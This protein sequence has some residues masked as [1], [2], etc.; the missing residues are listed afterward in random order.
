MEAEKKRLIVGIAAANLVLA[1]L[2]IALT[3]RFNS[4]SPVL[5]D[6]GERL[7]MG[8]TAHI[9]VV[10]ADRQTAQRCIDTGFAEIERIE[11]LMSFHRDDSEISKI[12]RGAFGVPVKVSRQT[13]QLIKRSVEL[14][15]FTGGAFDVTVGPLVNLWQQ[16]GESNSLPTDEELASVRSK[17]GYQK[18]I[19]NDSDLSVQFSVEGMR[20]DLGG[21]AKGYG[22]DM[23]V[24][25]IRDSGGIGGVVNIGGE[26]RCFGAS[27]KGKPGWLVGVQNPDLKAKDQVLTVLHLI[28]KAVSTSGDYHRFVTIGGQHFSHII[29]LKSGKSAGSLSSVTV[30]TEQGTD[31]D[32]LATAASVMGLEKGFILIE[33]TPFTEAIFISPGPD[34]KVTKTRGANKFVK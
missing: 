18:L 5:L 11:K 23:A 6:S 2:C 3:V 4:K 33:D 13:Y 19:L 1:I 12:N 31:A 9:T 15:E 34:Y 32:A 24:E 20:I 8:T 14:S 16:A 27:A 7:V 17:V 25:T 26:V 28:D 21:I 10:A 22:V 29:D 30:I